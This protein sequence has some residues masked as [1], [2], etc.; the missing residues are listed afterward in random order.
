MMGVEAE[1]P[2]FYSIVQI[3]YNI[4]GQRSTNIPWLLMF[5]G[6]WNKINFN[7][8]ASVVSRCITITLYKTKSDTKIGQA[9]L[10]K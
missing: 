9:D 8:Q 3:W 5:M 4:Q 6:I 1:T 2:L 10:S 7:H